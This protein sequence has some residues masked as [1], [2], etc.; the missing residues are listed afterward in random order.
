[1]ANCHHHHSHHQELFGE[2]PLPTHNTAHIHS[3]PIAIGVS[4]QKAWIALV[5]HISYYVLAANDLFGGP[6]AFWSHQYFLFGGHR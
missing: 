5:R 3:L 4:A 1:M 6:M 2:L